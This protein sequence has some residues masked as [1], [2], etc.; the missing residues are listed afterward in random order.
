MNG[1]AVSDKGFTFIALIRDKLF[2]GSV[3]C[4]YTC[5]NSR[6]CLYCRCGA[7]LPIWL[8]LYLHLQKMWVY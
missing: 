3:L 8:Q 6:T 5:S 2:V 7:R 4:L 1:N